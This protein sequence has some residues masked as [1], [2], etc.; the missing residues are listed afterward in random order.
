M[1]TDQLTEMMQAA[2]TEGDMDTAMLCERAL[3]GDVV[4]HDEAMSLWLC[5]QD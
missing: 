5:E 1:T 2:M 3:C 4:A